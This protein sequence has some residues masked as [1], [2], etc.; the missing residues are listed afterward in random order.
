VPAWL[1]GLDWVGDPQSSVP[2]AQRQLE[3]ITELCSAAG[4]HVERGVVGDPDPLTAIQDAVLEHGVDE[5]VL[6][7]GGRHVARG[8][9][10]SLANRAERLTG[11][12]VQ[13]ISVPRV[14]RARRHWVPVGGRCELPRPMTSRLAP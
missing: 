7:A 3:R 13:R 14:A 11:L 4:L 5:I 9:V 10:L 8:Y 1:H 2:C 6:F 12:R